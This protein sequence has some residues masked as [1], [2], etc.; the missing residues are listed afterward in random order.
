M[1]LRRH[2]A[3]RRWLAGQSTA[4][5]ALA[6]QRQQPAD[7]ITARHAARRALVRAEP[8]L[9]QQAQLQGLAAVLAAVESRQGRAVPAPVVDAALALLRHAAVELPALSDRRLAT[10]LAAATAALSGAPV[11]VVAA[12]DEDAAATA[13]ALRPVFDACGVTAAAL[14]LD[15]PPAALAAGYRADVVLAGVRRL[16]ADLARDEHLQ[17]RLGADGP[18]PLLTRGAV[19]ALLEPLDRVLADDALGPVQLSVA[20]DPSG[21]GAALALARRLAD[22]LVPGVHHDGHD[23]LDAGRDLLDS[24]AAAWPPLWRAAA[25]RDDLVRQALY[26]RDGLQRG[27]DYELAPG[28]LLWLDEGLSERL[29]ERAFGPG[30][31]QA[32]QLRLGVPMA[33]ITRTLGRTSVPAFCQRYRHLAGTA[34]A[35]AGLGAELWQAHGL[36]LHV[37]AEAPALPCRTL[38]LPDRAAWEQALADAAGS[39]ADSL[40]RLVVLRRAAD[41]TS[42]QALVQHPR[43]AWA[44]EAVGPQAALQALGFG[45]PDAPAG[46]RVVFAEPPDTARAELAFL[47]RAADASSGPF[48]AVRLIHAYS[49]WL[50]ERLPLPAALLRPLCRWWPGAAPRLLPALVAWAQRRTARQTR[51]HRLALPQRER[52]LQQQLSFTAARA[53]AVTPTSTPAP[54]TSP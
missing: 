7:L 37:A 33:P 51:A 43:A 34:P 11:H 4:L 14:S 46:L 9:Q 50:A 30:L 6:Q 10:A 18:V 25:R 31:S 23:L 2:Q 52:Q 40:A 1:G 5:A 45:G 35:L 3:R 36:V 27:R 28:N 32:L 8:L 22:T 26:V 47:R 48:E 17:S 49:R 16:A 38:A 19:W 20:D 41:L 24:Q 54:G 12:S 42:L 39:G 44:L 21:F 15:M 29:T 13:A 53:P